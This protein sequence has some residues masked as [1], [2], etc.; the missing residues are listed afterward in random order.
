MQNEK[1]IRFPNTHT[2]LHFFVPYIASMSSVQSRLWA[3]T[4]DEKEENAEKKPAVEIK[5]F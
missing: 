4:N 1:S 2:T 5:Y 3:L